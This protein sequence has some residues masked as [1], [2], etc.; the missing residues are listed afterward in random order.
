MKK[1]IAVSALCLLSM[2]LA[3]GISYAQGP[4]VNP[5]V[6]TNP[7]VNTAIHSDTSQPL[8]DL[9]LMQTVPLGEE[10]EHDV[11]LPKL[12]KQLA[13]TDANVRPATMAGT[14]P[15]GPLAPTTATVGVDVLGVGVGFLGYTVPDAPTDSNLSV[16][17]TQVVQWNNVSYAV[18][19]K[20]TGAVLAGPILGN[21]LWTGFGGG[22]ETHNSGDIIA[23]WDKVA[24][25]WVLFQP[26]FTAP[27]L[28][29]FAI[30]KTPDAS[31][32]YYR[33]SFPQAAGFPDYPKLGIW[34]N[35]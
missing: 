3:C 24:H 29:C 34:T 31:G 1:P 18:F 19:D 17:D 14:I 21:A 25:R 16:G 15:L 10:V 8:R 13:F 26:V 30:S 11:L 33:F 5:S 7:N 4:A 23:Q 27:F 6:L 22:C 28:S 12:A 2:A 9:A 32:A 35:A 20:T